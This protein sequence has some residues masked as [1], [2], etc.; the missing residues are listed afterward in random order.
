MKLSR[1]RKGLSEEVGP[2]WGRRARSP[3]AAGPAVPHHDIAILPDGPMVIE[4]NRT[5][6]TK[7]FQMAGIPL[8]R[9]QFGR[10]VL[11]QVGR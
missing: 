7:L 4:G 2:W 8:A 6:G 5:W 1:L 3:V 10:A 11:A 9:T